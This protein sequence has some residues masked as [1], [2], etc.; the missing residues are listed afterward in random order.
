[1]PIMI[2]QI[3]RNPLT[4]PPEI[5]ANERE[6]IDLCSL[7]AEATLSKLQVGEK[8][9]DPGQVEERQGRYGLNEV[10]HQKKLGFLG[11]IFQRCKNPLVIQLLII[12]GIS[13]A[14]GDIR[15]TIVVAAMAVLSVALG[16]FQESRA[17]RAVEKL[18]AMVRTTCVTLRNGKE[19]ELPINQLVPGDLVVLAA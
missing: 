4:K 1:M 18:Q 11:E 19:E 5:S 15:S 12:A 13:Y 16:Y 10:A 7:P 3:L 6:L 9:L 8:G 2:P 14:M 17:S